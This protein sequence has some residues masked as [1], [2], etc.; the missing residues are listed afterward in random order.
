M[1]LA[2]QRAL[3]P[4]EIQV[5][6]DIADG[7]AEDPSS[8]RDIITSY[9]YTP[10]TDNI[11]LALQ[12]VAISEMHDSDELVEQLESSEPAT[13]NVIPIFVGIGVKI[14]GALSG[15]VGSGIFKGKKGKRRDAA[16]AA[17][18]RATQAQE[19]LRLA[20]LKLQADAKRKRDEATAKAA[21]EKKKRNQ[22]I[23]AA[24]IIIVIIGLLAW[25]MS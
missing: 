15:L 21:E 24:I 7:I 16:A 6:G 22:Q 3:T 20:K 13:L 10:A 25:R 8:I 2:A 19:L 5:I 23:G 17:L 14:A 12:L 1:Q 18:Q 11:R 4:S 9:G